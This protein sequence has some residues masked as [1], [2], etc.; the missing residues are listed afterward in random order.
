MTTASSH[1]DT[2][3]LRALAE[4][5][6]DATAER[7]VLRARPDAL[8]LRVSLAEATGSV[9]VKLWRRPGWRGLLRR[10]TGTGSLDREWRVLNRLHDRGLRVPRPLARVHFERPRDD[11]TDA[12]VVEDLGRCEMAIDRLDRLVQEGQDAERVALEDQVIAMTGALLEA[13]VVDADH[14]LVNLLILPTGELGRIDFEIATLVRAPALFPG[15]YAEMLGALVSSYVFAVQPRVELADDFTARLVEHVRP[16]AGVLRGAGVRIE[17]A[18]RS[19]RE[20][21]GPETRW[22]PGW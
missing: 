7:E 4:A 13:G 15:R 1:H 10:A 16:P 18:L 12:V 19:Q 11:Y 21:G 20:G 6:A 17:R 3:G 9:I 8:T 22:V 2:L 14:H 5:A